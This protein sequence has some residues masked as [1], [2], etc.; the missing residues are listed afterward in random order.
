MKLKYKGFT[1]VELI[2]VIAIIGILAALLIPSMLGYVRK[3]KLKAANMN[4]KNTFSALNDAAI[5]LTT[6]GKISAVVKHGPIAVTDLYPGNE[7]EEA[8]KDCLEHNGINAGY[9]CWDVS[10]S[11][12]INCAQWA[13]TMSGDDWVG[14]YPNPAYEPDLAF[15]TIGTL[16]NGDSWT[17]AAR[18]S[19]T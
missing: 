11:K 19:F 17:D 12:K 4:A 2:V 14:Q 9:V 6:N 16:L 18:P 1:L 15:T 5:E 13:S 3:S 8:C 7:L 10:S